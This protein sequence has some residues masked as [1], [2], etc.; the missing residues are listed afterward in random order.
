MAN[1][2]H[3]E[4]LKQ[5]TRA[6][7]KWRNDNPNIK[8]DLSEIVI[9]QILPEEEYSIWSG[10]EQIGVILEN[11]NFSKTNLEGANLERTKL[12]RA[13]LQQAFL[14]RAN[15]GGANLEQANLFLANLEQANL[16]L[17]NLEKAN[18]KMALFD[19]TNLCLANL[20]KA[21]LKQA[22]LSWTTLYMAK[23]KGANFK[24]AKIG[25]TLFTDIDLSEVKNLDEAKHL[26]PSSIGIDTIVKSKGKI[27]DIFLR[28]CGVPD[29]FIDYIPSLIQGMEPIQFYSCFISYSVKDDAFAKRLHNDLQ[30]KGIRT[31]FAPHDMKIGDKIRDRIHNEIRFYDKLLVILSENSI[32]SDWVEDEVDTAFAKERESKKTVLFPISIDDHF[33]KTNKAWATTIRN[34]RHIGNFQDWKNHDKYQE[35]FEKLISDLQGK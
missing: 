28:S 5:G 15:L 14:F 17:A 4:I 11:I 10:V 35:M 32:N 27:P 6:W 8:P 25:S 12:F 26:S 22:N 19:L 20:K 3:I 9:N 29:S 33:E 13:N 21:N 7:N 1:Q 18:L 30:A 34:S 16:F 24:N 23:L 2:E 31:W